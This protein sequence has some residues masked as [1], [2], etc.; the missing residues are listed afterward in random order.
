MARQGAQLAI[1]RRHG[2]YCRSGRAGI[3]SA[4]IS[5]EGV[6]STPATSRTVL[7]RR[8]CRPSPTAGSRTRQVS[9]SHRGSLIQPCSSIRPKSM[10]SGGASPVQRNKWR[11]A[12]T[13]CFWFPGWSA[14]TNPA[15]TG[16]VAGAGSTYRGT[17]IDFQI[18]CSDRVQ[19]DLTQESIPVARCLHLRKRDRC[20]RYL[21]SDHVSAVF[22]PG[23]L[24]GTLGEGERFSL[25][26]HCTVEPV[27]T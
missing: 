11:R 17:P 19:G 20:C 7:Q 16:G 23:Q 1:V 12:R 26:E 9:T 10:C 6:G 3:I 24:P 5:L 15:T 27:C 13:R 14:A 2:R 21:V 25:A 8:S 22:D 18:E 4:S